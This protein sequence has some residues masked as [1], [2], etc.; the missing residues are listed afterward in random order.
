MKP[1][2]FSTLASSALLLT[3][4]AV[5]KP[6]TATA[7][8][9]PA[10][11][12]ERMN[13]VLFLVDDLGY[14]DMGYMG[15]KRVETPHI[16]DFARASILFTAAYAAPESSPTRSGILTGKNP[17][18]LHI[19]TWIPQ[20]TGNANKKNVFQGWTMPEEADGVA[21]SEYL[22]SEA[23]RDNGYDTWHIGKW[24]IGAA[25]SP[26]QRGFQ[27]D[28]GYWPWSYPKSYFSPYGL[29]T[30]KDGPPG[31][32]LTDRLTDEA[33]KLIKNHGSK[34]FF[35]NFWHYAVHE[36]LNAPQDEIDYY[37]HKGAP[38]E[39]KNNALYTA[40]KGSVD[41]SFGRVLKAI[42]DYGLA[43]K[44]IVIFFSDNGGVVKHADNGPLRDGKKSL[45]EG[46]I[47]V[48]LVI[49]DPRHNTPGRVIETPVSYIDFYPT[50][51]EWAGIDAQSVKQKLDG[52]SFA[53]L[54]A[55]EQPDGASANLTDRAL[56]WH[57]MG[58]FGHGPATAMR[59]DG[60]KLMKFYCRPAGKNQFELYDL[61]SDISEQHD[62]S[63]QMPDK[64][65]Q[66][67]AAIVQWVKEN[68]AQLPV[69]R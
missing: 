20:N 42:D 40:M 67:S 65:A 23:L 56:F 61:R 5:A 11:A 21:R 1:P 26:T 57:E 8:A 27:C 38:A 58:A 6:K 29:P 55:E 13:I 14:G 7:P 33:I 49:R 41:R 2:H 66:M 59:Q 32:Y 34:P 9:N 44:T 45:Y 54:L 17:A 53:P 48:P 25:F 37:A 22:L 50:F 4:A 46:G 31:E 63:E 68:G 35:L 60:Y 69:K 62:L 3:G 12:Q 36:P 47:R 52:V 51:L 30:L 43:D 16:D 18:R 28:I 39:G 24:H 15:N 19:T 64:V 10:P